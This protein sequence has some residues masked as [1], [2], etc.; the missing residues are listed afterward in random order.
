MLLSLKNY[1]DINQVVKKL[2][3]DVFSKCCAT[4]GKK[5]WLQWKAIPPTE[6]F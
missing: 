1:V 4:H 2:P 3:G 5:G 6:S